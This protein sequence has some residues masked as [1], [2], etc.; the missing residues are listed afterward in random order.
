MAP[1]GTRDLEHAATVLTQWLRGK[2]PEATDLAVSDLAQP[3]TGG[4]SN[5]M[6]FFTVTWSGGRSECRRELAAR[7]TTPMPS[8]FPDSDL[9]REFALLKAVNNSNVPIPE[10]LWLEEDPSILGAPFMTMERVRGR[11]PEDNPPYT[12]SGWVLRLPVEA[13]ARLYDNGLKA[14]ASVVNTDWSE[15]D[16][17]GLRRP[18]PQETTAQERIRFAEEYLSWA[19]RGRCFPVLDAGLAW[20]KDHCPDD[21]EPVTLSWGDSRLGNMVF[22]DDLNVIAALDWEQ[23]AFGSP[24][25]DLGWW[26]FSRR[27]HGEGL[28][29]PLPPGFPSRRK[30]IKRWEELTGRIAE[31]IDFYEMFNGVVGATAVM[32]I[33]DTMIQAGALPPDSTMPTHN[34][35]SLALAGMLGIPIGGNVTSWAT[36]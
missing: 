21:A 27:T 12:A 18:E 16:V 8:L 23:A 10:I 34:P 11:I 15:L 33:G 24:E 35:A 9:R 22:D 1:L 2:L 6:L 3:S 5:E 28:G 7:I 36:G 31:H 17:T 20:L 32:R 13:Q 25:L 29:L 14:L 4:Y 19:T 30:T 26:L